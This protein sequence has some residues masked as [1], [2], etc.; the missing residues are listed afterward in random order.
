MEGLHF[1]CLKPAKWVSA[2][3]VLNAV[4]SSRCSTSIIVQ[5]IRR[6][7]SAIRLCRSFS[8]QKFNG[9]DG[10]FEKSIERLDWNEDRAKRPFPCF[11]LRTIMSLWTTKRKRRF[12]ISFFPQRALRHSLPSTPSSGMRQGSRLSL[13]F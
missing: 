5:K 11:S 4:K 8:C 6:C 13:Y 10:G 2:I 1:G 12:R 3:M 9:N 7:S